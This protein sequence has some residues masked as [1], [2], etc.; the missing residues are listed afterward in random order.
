MDSRRINPLVMT[1]PHRRT[2]SR[3][4]QHRPGSSRSIRAFRRAH[5][6]RLKREEQTD[7]DDE[8]DAD[9]DDDDYDK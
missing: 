2:P 6:L 8:E 4:R 7:S 3:P 9:G 1:Q 5:C